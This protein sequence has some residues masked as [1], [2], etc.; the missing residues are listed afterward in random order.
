MT[1]L[2]DELTSAAQNKRGDLTRFLV[3]VERV[4]LALNYVIEKR[5]EE[6]C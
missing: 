4:L 1:Y 2:K 3:A 6:T 5:G